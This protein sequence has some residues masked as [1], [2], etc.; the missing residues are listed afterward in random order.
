MAEK[1]NLKCSKCG[2]IIRGMSRHVVF[3]SGQQFT[4]WC[5]G[6]LNVHPQN[7][8]WGWIP[9][10]SR[11]FYFR[12]NKNDVTESMIGFRQVALSNIG[13]V[14]QDSNYSLGDSG[15]V[16]AIGSDKYLYERELSDD[17]VEHFINETPIL[18]FFGRKHKIQ[19]DLQKDPSDLPRNEIGRAFNINI[20]I[21]S[22]IDDSI[23]VS[24]LARVFS[25]GITSYE[26]NIDFERVKRK[27]E[28]FY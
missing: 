25:T 8:F 19:L 20:S 15:V 4:C 26:A 22:P 10:L 2:H 21:K 3:E 17:F 16:T 6:V 13:K 14:I 27:Y 28:N 24:G 9:R 5:D 18:K 23:I 1:V 11:E 7:K 12:Q